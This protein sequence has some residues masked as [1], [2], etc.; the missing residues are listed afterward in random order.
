ML[1]DRSIGVMLIRLCILK[2]HLVILW[3]T[4]AVLQVYGAFFFF[5]FIFQCVPSNYFWT[6]YT[7]GKG[8]CIDTSVTVA[9][10]YGYSAISCAADLVFSIL[11]YFLVW[12]LQM[13]LRE[14]VLVIFILGMAAM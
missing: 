6:Q 11:P 4:L 7:G 9:A 10:T 1:I 8:R 5:L 2:T 3:T 14:R 13:K 12:N